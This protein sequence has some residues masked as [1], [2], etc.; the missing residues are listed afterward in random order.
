MHAIFE[1]IEVLMNATNAR[2]IEDKPLKFPKI[3]TPP[4]RTTKD[5][6]DPDLY[7]EVELSRQRNKLNDQ[8][9]EI[10]MKQK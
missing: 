9:N 10:E 2:E 7:T 5:T 3:V 1:N 6:N 8:L 4:W